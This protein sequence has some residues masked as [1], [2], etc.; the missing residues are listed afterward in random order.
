MVEQPWEVHHGRK[1]KGQQSGRGGNVNSRGGI[2]NGRGGMSSPNA[3]AGYSNHLARGRGGRGRGN[4]VY[5]P[6]PK[7]A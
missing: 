5:I 6:R 3:R 1:G 7:P 4:Y 2:G